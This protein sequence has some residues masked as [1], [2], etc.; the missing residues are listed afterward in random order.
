MFS[1]A[2][3][4]INV[5]RLFFLCHLTN[6][7][8]N[9]FNT[10]TGM[11]FGMPDAF[12]RTKAKEALGIDLPPL[13]E[14]AV[15]NVFFPPENPD[16]LNDCK[17]ILERLTKQRG[18]TVLGWRPVPVDNT[19]LGQ[20]PLDSEPDTEQVSSCVYVYFYTLLFCDI[21][22]RHLLTKFIFPIFTIC[23]SS[24]LLPIAVQRNYHPVTLNVN[25]SVFVKWQRK[26]PLPCSVLKVD[27]TLIHYPHK[28]SPTKDN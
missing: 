6:Y 13:G 14:Y 18:L 23:N 16:V 25:Y 21:I 5:H 7:Y 20:D 19:M 28:Q 15:G 9:S 4:I 1:Y 8:H 2:I 17:S 24:S 22:R 10:K 3:A 26:K 12:M 27:S 11:L